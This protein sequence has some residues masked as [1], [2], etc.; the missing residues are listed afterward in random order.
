MDPTDHGNTGA[1]SPHRIV[2]CPACGGDSV[3]SPSN[4][5]RP[6]CSDRC[7]NMD[8]GAWASETF[9]VPTQAAPDDLMFDEIP[10]H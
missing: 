1:A 9:R 3:Y 10:R 6:F 2:R 4:P 5:A 7:K 8:F